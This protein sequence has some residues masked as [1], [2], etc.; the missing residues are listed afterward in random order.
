[1]VQPFASMLKLWPDGARL[2]LGASAELPHIAAGWDKRALALGERIPA[3]SGVLPLSAL[4]CFGDAV[5]DPA[6]ERISPATALLRL[7]A[8]SSAS[9]LLDRERRAAE[10][11]MLSALVRDVPCVMLRPPSDP[12]DYRTFFERVFAWAAS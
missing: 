4:A 3:A 1:M 5:A 7:A 8:N 2:A 10:F 12:G 11:Q 6:V 9:H